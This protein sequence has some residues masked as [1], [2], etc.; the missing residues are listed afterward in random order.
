MKKH[1]NISAKLF[2]TVCA[3]LLLPTL[4]FNTSCNNGSTIGTELVDDEITIVVDSTFTVTGSSVLNEAVISRTVMQLLGEIDAPEFGYMSSDIVTQFMAAN[5][6]DT[7]GV[8]V[9]DVDSLKL[10]MLVN[11]G[12]YT[13]DSLALM[14]VKVYPLNKQLSAPI[15]SNFDPAG[16][17]DSSTLLGSTVY[18]LALESEPD[19]SRAATYHTVTVDLPVELGRKFFTEFIENPATFSSPSAF[20]SFFP[21][22]YITNS[23]GSGRL[24]RIGNTSMKLYYHQNLKTEAGKDTTIYKVGNYFAVTPEII[25]NNDITFDISPNIRDMAAEGN[26]LLV[27]PVGMNIELSFPGREIVAAYR[28]GTAAGLGVPNVL[29]FRLPVEAIENSHNIGMPT[30][31]LLILKKDVNDFFLQNKLPDNQTSFTA[32]VS[33][34]SDGTTVY[35]FPDMLQYVTNL[36]SKDSIAD[37]DVTFMLIPVAITVETNTNI[38][39]ETTT[40]MTGVTPY[41]SEPKMAKISLEK[42][43]I[44]FVYSKQTTKF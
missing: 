13:G 35:Y 27:A 34:M 14:G 10:V 1:K 30:D 8:T 2:G 22:L 41:V 18:N 24:T 16:Y 40:T 44:N 5:V 37:E 20:S 39:G 26:T 38:Y 33:T 15:Y 36:L 28:K 11:K 17:Y 42:A 29:S 43:K 31:V 19:S 32:S 9:A 25:S 23:Y 12:A 3:A 6:I 7:T 4:V 21:G